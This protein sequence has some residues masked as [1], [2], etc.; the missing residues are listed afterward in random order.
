MIHIIVPTRGRPGNT[1]R[2]IDAFTKTCHD[3]ETRLTFC[4]DDDD[5]LAETYLNAFLGPSLAHH[6]FGFV[7]GTR[8]RLGPTLNTQAVK[9]AKTDVDGI[10]FMGDDHLP[11]TPGW[12]V[13]YRDELRR[14]KMGIVYGNDLIQGENL[15]TQMCMTP[16]IIQTLGFMV[17]PGL[18]HLYIDNFW[19]SLG[20]AI[21]D[22]IRYLPEQIIQHM[23]PIAKG[24]EWDSTYEEAN[25][26]ERY[27]EDEKAWEAYRDVN[28]ATDVSKLIAVKA[29]L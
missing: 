6:T 16:N 5:P 4:I 25:A 3:P 15:P 14:M 18:L 29:G 12:D 23:H 10:G 20:R 28:F 17:P 27:A 7:A 1:M 26:Q 8:Q 11:L 22:G 13:V 19:L 21:P 9:I 24:A 2:L